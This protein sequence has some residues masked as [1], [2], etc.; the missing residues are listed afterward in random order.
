MREFF[1]PGC[2]VDKLGCD[3]VGASLPVTRD[4]LIQ[5]AH[6]VADVAQHLADPVLELQRNQHLGD[7]LAD[8]CL[9]Y[10]SPSPRD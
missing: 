10:T 8:G 5:F 6:V 1:E 4:S 7:F 9:L 2:G 3:A